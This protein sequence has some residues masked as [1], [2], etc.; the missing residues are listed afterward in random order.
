MKVFKVDGYVRVGA[1][2]LAH[3]DGLDVE[4]I[5]TP[6][7]TEAE[8]IANCGEADALMVLREPITEKVVAALRQCK[9]ISRFGVGLDTVDVEAATRAHVRVTNVPDANVDEVSSHAMAMILMLARR[10]KAYDGAVRA[11][12]WSS[13]A[14][15]SGIV[16]QN[17]QT[18]GIIGFGRIGRRVARK[19]RAFGYRMVACDPY[20]DDVI[21]QAE[22]VEPISFDRLVESADIVSIHV[23]VT[24]ETR[25]MMSAQ[26]IERMKRGAV[27]I[28]V[29]RGGLVDEVALG[30]ALQEGRL[31]GAGIDTLSKEPPPA[32]H[33]LLKLDNVI[34]SPHAA[35]YSAQSYNEVL[36]KAFADVAAVLGGKEPTYPVN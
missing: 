30:M 16:R 18:L 7:L 28:N 17:T 21:L 5:D 11:G 2:H 13:I 4:F 34:L 32:D 23:P 20:V 14:G 29:S 26:A 24:A 25:N 1:T 8:L 6:F 3:F 33:P 35:H 10:L 31:S 27:L 9:I 22:G 15:G 12:S 36:D 19:A